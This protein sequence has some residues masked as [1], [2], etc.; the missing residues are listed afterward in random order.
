MALVWAPRPLGTPLG[1]TLYD[2]FSKGLDAGPEEIVLISRLFSL[3]QNWELGQILMIKYWGTEAV[4][5][6]DCLETGISM[7]E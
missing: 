3:N 6:V 7:G 5:G 1:E 2:L 4:I